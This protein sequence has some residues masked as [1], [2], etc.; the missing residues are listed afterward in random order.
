MGSGKEVRVPKESAVGAKHSVW[1]LGN[2][3]WAP[4]TE[5]TTPAGLLVQSDG[6]GVCMT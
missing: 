2:L 6:E 4:V 3:P 5:E 1:V